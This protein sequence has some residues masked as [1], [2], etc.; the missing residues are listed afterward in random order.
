MSS[1]SSSA[2]AP[3]MPPSAIS[4]ASVPAYAKPVMVP[5]DSSKGAVSGRWSLRYAAAVV[6]ESSDSAPHARR[7]ESSRR[8]CLDHLDAPT[9]EAAH[10]ALVDSRVRDEDV[11]L[12]EPA[13]ADERARAHL[14]AVGE[15]NH[16]ARPTE[17]QLL[18]V[19]LG[20][21]RGREPLLERE[22][23]R[24]DQGAIDVERVEEEA[25]QRPD[26]RLARRAELAA[27]DDQ[28]RAAAGQLRCRGQ[29]VRDDRQA[30]PAAEQA[31]GFED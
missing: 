5:A 18:R 28:A 15:E 27:D 12:L 30:V 11:D 16:L 26:E 24:P 2:P 7:G 21:V 29:A 17:D 13:G 10:D 23:E 3:V 9:F 25:R 22:R 4:V 8:S 6:M 20:W 19:G 31:C 1:N 14:P